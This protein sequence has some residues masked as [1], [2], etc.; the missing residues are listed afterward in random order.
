MNSKNVNRQMNSD[1][2]QLNSN[3]NNNLN[4]SLGNLNSNLESLK[5]K[6]CIFEICPDLLLVPKV[7]FFAFCQDSNLKSC[8]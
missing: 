5:S 1:V 3:F 2:C 6:I 4:S 8:Q 7:V